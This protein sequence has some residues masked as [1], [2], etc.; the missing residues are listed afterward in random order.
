MTASVP[1]GRDA[2]DIDPNELPTAELA[3]ASP[4]ASETAARRRSGTGGVIGLRGWSARVAPGRCSSE[5]DTADACGDR[6]LRG[7]QRRR[8]PPRRS[9]GRV[10]TRRRRHRGRQ[11]VSDGPHRHRNRQVRP[12]GGKVLLRLSG[13]RAIGAELQRKAQCREPVLPRHRQP[14]L[15]RR[16]DRQLPRLLR[17]SWQG[18]DQCVPD[19]FRAVLRRGARPGAPVLHRLPT[20]RGCLSGGPHLRRAAAMVAAL[21]GR[22]GGAVEAGAVPSP[23]VLERHHVRQY[24]GD[25]VAVRG[26]GCRPGAE[27][28]PPLVRAHRAQRHHL[29]RGGPGRG[30]P[31]PV[32]PA[33]GG[34]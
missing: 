27:R 29:L 2:D 26:L 6:R 4:I 18:R 11:P 32:R 7:R 14:R 20:H 34:K 5:R 3:T 24:P 33:R 28:P 1:S 16:A 23:R 12:R 15:H 22:I 17:S 13:G 10:E 25:A 21:D 19:G 30:E 31:L 8:V 9:R